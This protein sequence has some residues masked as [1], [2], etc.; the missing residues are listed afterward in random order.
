[1][2]SPVLP[3]HDPHPQ[4]CAPIDFMALMLAVRVQK[5][6]RGVTDG[7]NVPIRVAWLCPFFPS[8]SADLIGDCSV[9][10]TI[11]DS[12]FL[13]GFYV[14]R[15]QSTR[16]SA[17]PLSA[18]L[19]ITYTLHTIQLFSSYI[20]TLLGVDTQTHTRTNYRLHSSTQKIQ[21]P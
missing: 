5:G 13:I 20:N 1:M 21:Y 2:T 6:G 10:G 14:S 16:C 11:F 9:L 18:L 3:H 19:L 7:L 8:G 4:D 17:L 15:V 12:R